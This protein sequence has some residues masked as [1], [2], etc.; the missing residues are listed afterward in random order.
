LDLRYGNEDKQCSIMGVMQ[1]LVSFVEEDGDTLRTLVAGKH[2]YVF[3][4]KGPLVLVMVAK[5]GESETH[6]AMQLNYVFNQ[7]VYVLTF[8][9]MQRIFDQQTNFDLRRMLG[10]T[11]KYIDSLLDLFE[12]DP[13]FFLGAVRC[14]PLQNSIRDKIGQV[15]L[16]SRCY[17]LT[18]TFWFGSRW[19]HLFASVPRLLGSS[20][21]SRASA[22][23]LGCAAVL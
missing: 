18:H 14:L 19:R 13:S 2:K 16:N 23:L 3:Q 9:Q 4:Q 15:L 20:A 1:A 5:T 6:M 17:F 21:G 10:G 12:T 7:I 11:E 8:A 22:G